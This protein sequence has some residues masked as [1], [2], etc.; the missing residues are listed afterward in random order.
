VI[1]A[2]AIVEVIVVAVPA[3]VP[4]NVPVYVPLLLSVTAENVPFETPPL[5]PTAT[6]R[7]PLVKEFPAASFA[8]I[9][10]VTADPEATL[11]LE[12]LTIDCES[13]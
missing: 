10:I 8:V 7:P 12:T 6:E 5:R 1:E 11:P 3:V 2:P 4:V 13:E 9:V